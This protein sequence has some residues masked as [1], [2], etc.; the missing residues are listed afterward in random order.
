MMGTA[1]KERSRIYLTKPAEKWDDGFPLGNGRLGLMLFGL[2]DE[3]QIIINEETVWYGGENKKCNPDMREQIPKIRELLVEGKV[4]EAE[5]LA[6]M[7]MTS[8]PKYNN[9]YQPA[10]V[11][12]INFLDHK[13]PVEEYSR[14][15]DLDTAMASVD[16]RMDGCAYHR[17]LFV[18][19]RYQVGVIHIW[20][21]RPFSVQ[22]NI[23]RR[24]FEE[25]TGTA[26]ETTAVCYGQNGVGGVRYCSAVRV[27][28]E[29][30]DGLV[31]TMGDYVF[32]RNV[33]CVTFYV[34]CGTDFRQILEEKESGREREDRECE[35]QKSVLERLTQAE[36]TGYE[37]VKEEHIMDYT[38]LFSRMSLQI[39]AKDPGVPTDQ[40]LASLK[41]GEMTYRDYLVQV[42]FDYARYLEIGSSYDCMLPSNLQGIWNG[43]HVPSWLSQFTININT[44][45]N[46][47]LTDACGL[48][49]CYEPLFDFVDRMVERGRKTAKEAYGCR[50]FCAHHNSNLWANTDV[51]GVLSS[52]PFWP[53]GGA[54]MSLSLYEHYTYHPDETFLRKRVLPVLKESVLFFYDYLYRA[55][56]G[57]WIT[58]PSL[59]PENSYV[60]KTGEMGA[61]CMA[62]TMDS[63]ILRQLLTAYLEGSKKLGQ[64]D[65][66]ETG[67]CVQDMAEEILRHLP[68]IALTKDGR[69]R[70][71]QEDYQEVELGHR[72]ISHLYGLYP[73]HEIT[74]EKKEFFQAAR[75]TLETRLAHG[76]GHTGWSKSWIL[77]FYARLRD[78]NAFLKNLTELLQV[79]IQDNMLDSHP[80]F[81]IDGNFGSAAG[82]A[83]ALVQSQDDRIVILPA[84]P[85]A[86]KDG[87][88]RGI[89]LRGGLKADME[90]KDGRL[91]SFAV[92]AD[93]P[94]NRWFTWK[95]QT[96]E[97]SLE[98][99]ET[100]EIAD[101]F[102]K[103]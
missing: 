96:V 43:S 59:S 85:D 54:W 30:E 56:D 87:W 101:L 70:E 76:G 13:Y 53:M 79:S 98:A 29:G 77:C 36:K 10:G 73:G 11:I 22:A 94:G 66:L 64:R 39:G 37:K 68:S 34:A 35:I 57:S 65:C 93:I 31:G 69:I 4:S 44:E 92:T 55:K 16:Y 74:A 97:I 26:D 50:G 46:Y 99:G 32:A 17:E 18:S 45:M 8:T 102:G 19:H 25:N 42:L 86:W 81:Q 58:G 1:K 90:W 9:P 23:N 67:E 82:I 89:C 51:D 75:K 24:P 80:P 60:S 40:M 3:E 103:E 27:C 12:R 48:P 63:M 2:P 15:L 62:P 72:H 91:A 100:K 28:K 7:A 38:R 71:W 14:V 5:F 49:E 6:K 41:R 88:V 78:G 20:A 61:I 21:D 47:W 33:K 84:L 83:E 52:S 95:E